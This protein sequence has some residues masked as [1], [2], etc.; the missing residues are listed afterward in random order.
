MI[1]HGWAAGCGPSTREGRKGLVKVFNSRLASKVSAMGRSQIVDSTFVD[2][3]SSR[4]FVPLADYFAL[5][6]AKRPRERDIV[7]SGRFEV[8]AVAAQSSCR[9]RCRRH[10][11]QIQLYSCTLVETA[12]QQSPQRARW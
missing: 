1:L 8:S 2:A 10:A 9:Q 5:H 11:V 12:S 3:R 4:A 6:G 7:A